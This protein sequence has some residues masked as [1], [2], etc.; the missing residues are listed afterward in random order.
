MYVRSSSRYYILF[1]CVLLYIE[2]DEAT[3]KIYKTG[4][5]FDAQFI[6]GTR[7]QFPFFSICYRIV[8]VTQLFR[9]YYK[10]SGKNG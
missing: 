9:L 2:K 3:Y 5:V 6:E 10:R 1:P 4:E 8:S 7:L